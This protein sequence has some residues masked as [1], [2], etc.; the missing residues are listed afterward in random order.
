MLQTCGNV[1]KLWIW[2]SPSAHC[3]FDFFFSLTWCVY[4]SGWWRAD[5]KTDVL[6]LLQSYEIYSGDPPAA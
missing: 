6:I 4:V 1:I 5:W 3:L 2:I